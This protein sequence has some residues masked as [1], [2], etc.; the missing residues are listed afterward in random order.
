MSKKA[1]VLGYPNSNNLG[2]FVQS[3]A[4][5]QELKQKEL[6]QLDRDQLHQYKG[7]AIKLIMNGWFMEHPTHWPPSNNIDPLFLSFHLNPIAKKG[8]LDE[9]GI[10]YLKKQEPIGCRDYHTQDLLSS[11]GIKT[12]FSACLTLCL[13]RSLY[14]QKEKRE[15]IHVIS[16]IERLNPETESPS[17]ELYK[18]GIQK[19]KKPF[20]K[21]QYA[22]AMSRL[23]AFL[24]VQEEK[25][26]YSTQLRDIS[27]FSE[28]ERINEAEK[29]LKNIAEARLVITSRIHTALPAVAFNTP[30]LF[31]SDGLEHPNQMSR[32]K[33][34]EQFFPII[35]YKELTLWK[36]QRPKPTKAHLPFVS[37]FQEEILQFLKE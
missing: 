14:T 29:H 17:K 11:F 5:K 26:Y 34:M 36:T 7:E 30:V 16:P 12:Y 19:L 35:N 3:L 6:I 28:V 31:L 13:N 37:K 23:D 27:E 2:D 20:K 22:K 33:G 10:R 25:K 8:M 21:K 9:K 32:L 24:K 15:G 4:A 18:R 1:A